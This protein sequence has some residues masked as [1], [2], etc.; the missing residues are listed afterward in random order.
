MIKCKL[1]TY[2]LHEPQVLHVVKQKMKLT[3]HWLEIPQ[4][5][6]DDLLRAIKAFHGF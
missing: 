1:I 4:E 3:R 5:Y 2:F 6:G